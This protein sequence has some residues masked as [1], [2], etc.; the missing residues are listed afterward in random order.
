MIRSGQNRELSARGGR[1]PA[2][3][4]N[5]AFPQADLRRVFGQGVGRRK[6]AFRAG[7]YARVSTH[8][9]Q[10]LP[11]QNRALREYAARR[12]WIVVM[13]VKEVSSGAGT[14]PGSRE[15]AG[16]RALVWRLDRWGRSVTDPHDHL[17]G[18]SAGHNTCS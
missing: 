17:P 15:T 14:T 8:D 6:A 12:G 13:Q 10:T 11:M 1:P 5:R 3:P 16:G 2:L 4:E 9:Q 7:L 18:F